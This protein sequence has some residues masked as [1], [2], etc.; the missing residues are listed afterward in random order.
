MASVRSTSCGPCR[1][2]GWHEAFPLE[3]D[4][5]V[6]ERELTAEAI[7]RVEG[8]LRTGQRGMRATF[9]ALMHDVQA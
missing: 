4:V 2:R 6:S 7:D 1:P 9:P 5:T 8:A 3:E